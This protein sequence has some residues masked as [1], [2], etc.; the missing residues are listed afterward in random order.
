[1][2]SRCT[3]GMKTGRVIEHHAD[4]VDEDS[5]K[6]QQQPSCRPESA[7]AREPAAENGGDDALRRAGKAQDLREGGR[8][9]DD[10]EDHR[11]RCAT[12]PRKACSK[13]L[14][15]ERA[16]G[17]PP[18]PWW[19]SAPSAADS[20]GVAMPRRHRADHHDEDRGQRKDVKHEQ[21]V[22]A[23]SRSCFRSAVAG[24]RSGRAQR[25]NDDV[26]DKARR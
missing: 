20:V 12:V 15:L 25:A 10:E 8:A 1:M 26:A 14:K 11:R 2:S 16:I 19:Q 7:K 9:E 6:D 13:V 3:I 24:A 22:A 23:P 5:E 18:A 4:L 21:L 17:R